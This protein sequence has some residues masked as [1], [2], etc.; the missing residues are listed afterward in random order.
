MRYLIPIISLIGVSL[1]ILL[2]KSLGNTDL[3]SNETFRLL[4]IFN[5][6][7]IFALVILISIQIYRLLSGIKKQIVGSKLTLRLVISFTLMIII[8]VSIVY[9]VSVSFLTK[10]INSWFDVKVESALE[11]GLSLGQKT[12]NILMKDVELKSRSISYT[13]GNTAMDQRRSVL[14]DMREKFNIEEVIIYDEQLK[15]LELS[16]A[17]ESQIPTIPNY[18][19]IEKS[20]NG[21][22]GFIEEVDNKILLRAYMPIISNTEISLS[23]SFLEIKQPIPIEIANLAISVESVYEDYQRLAYSRKSLNIIYTLTLTLVLLLSILSAVA[24]SFVISRKF[25]E[26]LSQLA[27]ATREISRGNFNKAIPEQ[28]GKDELGLLVK[29]F[30]SMTRQLDSATQ[31]AKN[32]QLRLELARTFL[33]TILTNLTSGVVVIDN[34]KIVKLHNPAGLKILQIKK[35]PIKNKLLDDTLIINPSLKP[36]ISFIYAYIN[37]SMIN[38]E[39]S[40]EFKIEK[41][42]VDRIIRIQINTITQEDNLNY[43]LLI[44]DITDLTDAQ[45]NK[46]WSEVARRLAHEIKNPLTPIQLSAERVEHKLKEKLDDSDKNIL[47]KA[48]RTIVNQVNALKIMVNEFT[49]YARPTKIQ[50]NKIDIDLLIQNII[51]LYEALNINISYE[52]KSK[53]SVIYGDENKLRQ[54]VINLIDNAKD[55]MVNS[56]QPKI[57]ITIKNDKKNLFL[58]ILDN[59]KGIPKEILSNI[60]EP[61]VTSKTHGTGLGLAIVMK[62]IYEHNGN[63]SIK[64]NQTIGAKVIIKL[65]MVENEKS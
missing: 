47:T 39:S 13:I 28:G 7:F 55:A 45:R 59:G 57:D 38:K 52:C 46:V 5:I 51:D 10:S 9:L 50:K 25:S 26:P 49:E 11:G 37:Q 34:K 31:D 22:Y 32:N 15:I 27:N 19:D 44:D 56:K 12:L 43:I 4:F 24:I 17:N 20:L 64:N 65:P 40:Q 53:K 1:L 63:I 33:D 36:I 30:N 29:S 41:K 61:Y 2:A 6:L 54:V 42:G 8:P 16:S 18:E 3:I 21:F 35:S 62:I 60:F 23:K 58:E 48:T 14:T